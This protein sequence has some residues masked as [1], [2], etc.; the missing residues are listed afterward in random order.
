[1]KINDIYLG[2]WC[3]AVNIINRYRIYY[4]PW[5]IE[6]DLKSTFFK[7]HVSFFNAVHSVCHFVNL[8]L[9][10]AKDANLFMDINFIERQVI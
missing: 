9:N 8:G 4:F 1:M 3:I 7:I 6:N 5:N 2:L 10:V